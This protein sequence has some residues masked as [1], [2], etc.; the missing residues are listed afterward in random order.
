[1]RKGWNGHHY[2]NK[3]VRIQRNGA[4]LTFFR[5]HQFLNMAKQTSCLCRTSLALPLGVILIIW[6]ATI[7]SEW[8]YKVM[9]ELLLLKSCNRRAI[10]THSNLQI[11]ITQTK[12]SISLQSKQWSDL[13]ILPKWHLF[14]DT[15][16][17]NED[18]PL[19]TL[20]Y[21]KFCVWSQP[22]YAEFVVGSGWLSMIW[23]CIS[24]MAP[25]VGW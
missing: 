6:S 12:R 21:K 16:T 13:H 4:Y 1:M 23:S 25:P 15:K 8:L 22:L 20:I 24:K 18:R 19:L 9:T 17:E 11:T 5:T 3:D 7:S 10:G 2:G 14:T